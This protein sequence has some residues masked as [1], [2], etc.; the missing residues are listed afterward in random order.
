MPDITSDITEAN[1]YIIEVDGQTAGIAARDGKHF[2]FHASS[3]LFDGLEGRRFATPREA[4]KAASA[5]AVGRRPALPFRR[6]L[7]LALS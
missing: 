1:A 7:S 5:L 4:E 2:R 6:R 3:R